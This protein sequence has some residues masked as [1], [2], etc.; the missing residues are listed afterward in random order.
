MPQPIVRDV[1]GQQVGPR[2][3]HPPS[4]AP[5]SQ[6]IQASTRDGRVQVLGREGVQLTLTCCDDGHHPPAGTKQLF[7]LPNRGSLVRLDRA[8]EL[9]L[10]SVDHLE[11]PKAAGGDSSPADPSS[12]SA[13]AALSPPLARLRLPQ[14]GGDADDAITY[15]VAMRRE[16]YVLVGCRGGAVRVVMAANASGAG[17]TAARQVRALKLMPYSSE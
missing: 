17:V 15:A 11:S 4:H 5:T 1:S 16:P 9:Q 14:E 2:S 10:L 7:F 12:G 3:R 6:H 8:G 13:P